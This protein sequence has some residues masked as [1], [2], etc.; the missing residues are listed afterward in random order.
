MRQAEI[1][2]LAGV[3][4]VI[5]G[6]LIGCAET[7]PPPKAAVGPAYNRWIDAL[8]AVP[9][10]GM[11]LADVS[12]MLGAPPVKCEEVKGRKE[13]GM[14]ILGGK[15]EV[16]TVFPGGAAQAAG[17]QVGDTILSVNGT[18]LAKKKKD[19]TGVLARSAIDLATLTGQ[20]ISIETVRGTFTVTPQVPPAQS[21]CYWEIDFGEVTTSSV[22]SS[23]SSLYAGGRGGSLSLHKF[24]RASCR[25][26][27]DLLRSCTGNFQ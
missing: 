9:S 16:T 26:Q 24:F 11:V 22:A 25:V 12:L 10:N 2:R 23:S 8:V 5:A 17:I 14:E 3:L 27:G 20:P 13:T 19:A 4:L 18:P 7:T 1:A 15:P 6:T 21:Q